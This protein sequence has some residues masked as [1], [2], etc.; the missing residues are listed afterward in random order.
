MAREYT[1]STF[2]RQTP[3]DLLARYFAGRG[4]LPGFKFDEL[5]KRGYQPLLTEIEALAESERTTIDRDFQDIFLLSDREGTQ[6]IIEETQLAGLAV[7]DD[8]ANMENG[9]ARAMWLFLEHSADE[10]FETC[11]TLAFIKQMSF[12][13]SKRR[14]GLPNDTPKFDDATLSAIADDLK[15]LYRK[16]GRGYECTV[17][18]YERKDPTRHCY[19]AWPED[20]AT[21]DVHYESGELKR[22]S[23]RS[24]FQVAFVF[25]PDEGV[26]EIAAPGDRRKAEKLQALFC[27]HALGLATL[28]P[29]SGETY[30]IDPLKARGFAFPTDPADM[31]ETVRVVGLKLEASGGGGRKVTVERS[32][33]NQASFYDWLERV[34]NVAA[35]PLASFTVTHATLKVTWFPP[36]GQRRAPTLTVSISP[37]STN[38]KEQPRHLVLKRYLKTWN[39]AQ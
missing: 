7:T 35:L 14:H 6:V 10:L 30:E 4:L 19:F 1:L 39:I 26:L 33:G 38:L 28:P 18:H 32:S 12:T 36:L 31:I 9:F 15:V 21:S 3:N 13:R 8:I 20:Y 27:K 5:T 29:P 23:R 16:E 24:A 22:S 2:L 25:R 37:E 11:A 17:E 34:I